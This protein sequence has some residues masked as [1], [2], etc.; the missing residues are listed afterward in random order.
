MPEVGDHCIGAKLLPPRGD[1]MAR[2]QVGARSQDANGNVMGSFHTNPTLN[3]RIYQVE[4]T[5]GEVTELTANV[6]A[7]SMYAGCNSD[8][9]E[10]LLLDV[11]VD[12]QT[13]TK[14]ISLS[15]QQITVQGRPVT[16]KTTRGWHICCQ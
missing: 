10:Y 12:Y 4:S 7:E 15:D 2:G 9:N 1:K 13:D 6:I 11:L 16:W 14:A 3:M 8:M 5:G